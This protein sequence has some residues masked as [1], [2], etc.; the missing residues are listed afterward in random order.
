MVALTLDSQLLRKSNSAFHARRIQFKESTRLDLKQER[1][2]K[3]YRPINAPSD[4]PAGSASLVAPVPYSG[5]SNS[6]S[7]VTE[8]PNGF[9]LPAKVLY[10]KERVQLV[11]PQPRAIGP[12]LVNLGNTCFLNSVLQCLTYTAPLANYLLSNQHNSSCKTTNFCMMCLLEKHVGRCFSHKM[13]EAI[14]PKVIV[15]RLR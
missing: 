15:G 3:K 12:G 8:D 2:K 9:R 13:S 6:S 14:A 1:L 10:S 11:W 7:T 5:I 4:G